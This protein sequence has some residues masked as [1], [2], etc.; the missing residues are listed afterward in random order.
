MTEQLEKSQIMRHWEAFMAPG[1]EVVLTARFEGKRYARLIRL[2]PAWPRTLTTACSVTE[3]S[4]TFDKSQLLVA[5]PPGS[6]DK[7]MD[8][9][10]LI[11]ISQSMSVRVPPPQMPVA[12]ARTRRGGGGGEG[13]ARGRARECTRAAITATGT[14]HDYRDAGRHRQR[15]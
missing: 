3:P 5:V 1:T 4:T 15:G 9:S 7:P 10:Q 12:N 13:P 14:G 11:E 2:C 6:L 8:A